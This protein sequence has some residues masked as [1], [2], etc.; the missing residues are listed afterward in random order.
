MSLAKNFK[1]LREYRNKTQEEVA[2]ANDV[3]Q[4]TIYKIENG[5]IKNPRDIKKYADYFGVTVDFLYHGNSSQLPPLGVYS[6][7]GPI[8]LNK[9][10]GLIPVLTSEQVATNYLDKGGKLDDIKT[11]PVYSDDELEYRIMTIDS[12]SMMRPEGLSIESGARVTYDPNATP[13]NG[14]L[15]IAKLKEGDTQ[16]FLRQYIDEG[17]TKGFKA[18]NPLF[19]FVPM[20]EGSVIYGV[21][22]EKRLSLDI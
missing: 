2:T 4:Q 11:V 8:D 9:P 13:T 20:T 7:T 12:D 6:E 18:F 10:V 1:A 19:V 17:G 14:K 21:A 15:V 5:I 3:G 22:K 16:A